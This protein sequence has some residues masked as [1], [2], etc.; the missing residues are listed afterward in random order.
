[1]NLTNR[2]FISIKDVDRLELEDLLRLAIA[3][4]ADR[5][6]DK[7]GQDKH[8]GVLFSVASTR[9]RRSFQIAAR[10]LGALVVRMYDTRNDMDG[11]P[12]IRSEQVIAEVADDPQSIIYD[13][14]ERR[15]HAQNALLAA[16]LSDQLSSARGSAAAGTLRPSYA[17]QLAELALV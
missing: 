4:K 13:Q 16:C 6:H 7:H 15:L 10:Q 5:N 2:D 3:I 17:A 14:A 11:M 1:M 9:T 8:I 12:F